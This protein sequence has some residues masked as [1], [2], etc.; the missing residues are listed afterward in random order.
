MIWAAPQLQPQ[1]YMYSTPADDHSHDWFYHQQQRLPENGRIFQ[2]ERRF[3]WDLYKT[4]RNVVV[5]PEW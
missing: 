3:H 4:A 2:K 5:G 1:F